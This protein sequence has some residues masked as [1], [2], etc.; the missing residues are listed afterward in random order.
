MV[1]LFDCVLANIRKDHTPHCSAAPNLLRQQLPFLPY[2]AY[3]PFI[4]ER[5]QLCIRVKRIATKRV[6]HRD[7]QPQHKGEDQRT[8]HRREG[9]RNQ[10]VAN[11]ARSE[12]KWDGILVRVKNWNLRIR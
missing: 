6:N 12:T 5:G 1:D 2:P 7:A 4:G 8:R 9:Q 10:W 3:N 11:C